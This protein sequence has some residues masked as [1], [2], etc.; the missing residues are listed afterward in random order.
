MACL[1]VYLQ[2][3]MY[4]GDRLGDTHILARQGSQAETRVYLQISR[5][6]CCRRHGIVTTDSLF[7]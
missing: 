7:D 2:E 4:F 6:F 1:Q 3:N 5:R